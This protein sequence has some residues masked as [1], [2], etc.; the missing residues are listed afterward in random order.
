MAKIDGQNHSLK[1]LIPQRVL[2]SH[3]VAT[4]AGQ[5]GEKPPQKKLNIFEIKVTLS[6]K[7]GVRKCSKVTLSEKLELERVFKSDSLGE[8]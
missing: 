7:L 3:F 2:S 4:C 1:F 8:N 6:E 5:G